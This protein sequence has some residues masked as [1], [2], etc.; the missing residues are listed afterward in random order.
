MLFPCLNRKIELQIYTFIHTTN[1]FLSKFVA[2]AENLK[3]GWEH[4]KMIKVGF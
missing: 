1:Q 3:K 4:A 2:I